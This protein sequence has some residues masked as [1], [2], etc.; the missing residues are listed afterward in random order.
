MSQVDPCLKK[1]PAR[2]YVWLIGVLWSAAAAET[3]TKRAVCFLC[4]LHGQQL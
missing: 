2:S 3:I 4:Q 1:D